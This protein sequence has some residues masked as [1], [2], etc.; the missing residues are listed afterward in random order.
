MPIYGTSI[1]DAPRELSPAGRIERIGYRY[2]GI[3]SQY[4]IIRQT[5]TAWNGSA[6]VAYSSND[7]AEY[8][9]AAEVHEGQHRSIPIPG[10]LPTGQTYIIYLYD[11]NGAV[12]DYE[13]DHTSYTDQRIELTSSA[14]GS[15]EIVERDAVVIQ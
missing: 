6:M 14:R 5:G 11:Q 8:A 3:K 7:W 1:A 12:P 15:V 4:A 10:G 13:A 9:I 2:S